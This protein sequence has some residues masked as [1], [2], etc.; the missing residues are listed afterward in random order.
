MIPRTDLCFLLLSYIQKPSLL[1]V[2]RKK[3]LMKLMKQMNY[4]VLTSL[5]PMKDF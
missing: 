4:L 2:K 1:M 3:M 5:T